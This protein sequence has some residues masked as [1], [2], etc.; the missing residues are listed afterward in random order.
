MKEKAMY[1]ENLQLIYETFGRGQL[2][3]VKAAAAYVGCD[4]R[5]LKKQPDLP[6]RKLGGRYY[7]AAVTLANWLA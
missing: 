4:E 5:T 3:P 2:I 7:V 6:L 1:R